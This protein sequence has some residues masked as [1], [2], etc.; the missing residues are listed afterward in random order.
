MDSKSSNELYLIKQ[1]LNSIIIELEAIENGV[2]NN[3][4]GIGNDK[5]ANSINTVISNYRRVKRSLDNINT[6]KVTKEF[7]ERQNA[8]K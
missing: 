6:S 2:R 8:N 4:V 7:A 1:E 5:C 3:F